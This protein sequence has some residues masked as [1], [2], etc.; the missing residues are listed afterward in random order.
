MC[1]VPDWFVVEGF[2][3]GAA[4][5]LDDL[6]VSPSEQKKEKKKESWSH[7]D[8]HNSPDL[9]GPFF[10]LPVHFQLNNSFVTY[11]RGR[12]RSYES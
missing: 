12:R 6:R 1:R 3:L 10:L 7:W 8:E 2:S 9:H 4:D 5:Y 11:I